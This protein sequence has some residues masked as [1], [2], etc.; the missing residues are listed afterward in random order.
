MNRTV[1]NL[2]LLWAV[3]MIIQVLILDHICLWNVAV[4]VAFIYPLLRLTALMPVPGVLTVGFISGMMVDM[5]ADTYGLNALCCTVLA[6]CRRPLLTM[7]FSREQLTAGLLPS[8]RSLGAATY[9]KY[10]V[11]AT[12]V[13]CVLMFVLGNLYFFNIPLMLERIVASTILS[14]MIMIGID[15]L[16]RPAK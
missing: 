16:M 12:L 6:L 4:P 15:A 3:I 8:M 11:T 5:F 14:A 9:I 10:M 2:I 1:F 7:Y 13:Y